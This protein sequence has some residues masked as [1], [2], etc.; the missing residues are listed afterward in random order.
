MLSIQGKG[1]QGTRHLDFVDGLRA[2]AVLS[3]VIFHASFD[4]LVPALPFWNNILSQSTHGVELFF[5]IS[6]FCLAYP[7]LARTKRGEPFQFD[8]LTFFAKRL[9]RIYP[10]YLVALAA[11]CLLAFTPQWQALAAHIPGF[12]ASYTWIGTLREVFLLDKGPLHNGSFWTL[13]IELRWYLVFPFVIASFGPRRH[14]YLALAIDNDCR[15]V[16]TDE[17]FLC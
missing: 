16:T 1:V 10:A 5:V 11:F 7:T 3:V 13:G 14:L 8:Y 17:R 9:T 6:G 4:G 12:A 15:F 2:V